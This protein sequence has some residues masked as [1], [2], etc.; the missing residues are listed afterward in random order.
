M[1]PTAEAGREEEGREGEGR[2]TPTMPRFCPGLPSDSALVIPFLLEEEKRWKGK[3]KGKRGEE[4]R[5][6]TCPPY[7]IRKEEGKREGK[8][9]EGCS[10]PSRLAYHS[11]FRHTPPREP[12]GVP[13]GQGEKKEEEGTFSS[14]CDASFTP[15]TL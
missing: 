4:E 6:R 14:R 1:G 7:F 12:D 10:I 8:E 11:L 3:K 9:G 5:R 13:S 15:K 2:G